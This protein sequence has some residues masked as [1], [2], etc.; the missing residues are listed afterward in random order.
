MNANTNEL[1]TVKDSPPGWALLFLFYLRLSASICGFFRSPTAGFRMKPFF[2][3]CH[4]SVVALVWDALPGAEP[5]RDHRCHSRR[6]PSAPVVGSPPHR[7]PT[8]K[9]QDLDAEYLLKLEPDRLLAYFLPARR[10]GG[11]G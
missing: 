7:R 8:Q 1:N 9:A 5:N 3:A 10:A 6:G 11:Q 4:R 2:L